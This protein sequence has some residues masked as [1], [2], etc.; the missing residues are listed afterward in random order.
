L[1]YAVI[2][3]VG[4]FFISFIRRILPSLISGTDIDVDMITPEFEGGGGAPPGVP[5]GV[6]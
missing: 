5:P 3:G 6:I 2:G 4:L 1:T